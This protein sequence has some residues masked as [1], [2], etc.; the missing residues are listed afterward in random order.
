MKYLMM[1]LVVTLLVFTAGESLLYAGTTGKVVGKITD[2]AT[3]EPLISANVVIKGTSLGAVSDLDG[4][5]II[6]NIPPGVYSVGVSIIGYQRVQF[7]GVQ[8]NIDLTTTIDAALKAEAV[9]LETVVITAERKLVIKDMTSSLSTTTAD[10]IQ[11]LPVTNVQQVLRLN[12][13]ITESD[14]RLYI[15]GGRAAEVGY[16]VDGISATDLYNGKLG[17]TVENSAIQELQV[18]SGTFNAEYGQAMSG[19]VN[20]VTKEG[21]KKYTGQI[22]V[23]A[24]DYLSSAD[25]FSLYKSIATAKDTNRL[26]GGADY[27]TRIVSGERDYPLKKFNPVYNGEFS[28]SGPV[29]LTNDALTFFANGRYYYDEGYYYGREWFKPN[30]NLG[31]NVTDSVENPNTLN[32]VHVISGDNSNLVP[33]NPS[34]TM[35]LLGKLNYQLSGNIKLSYSIFWNSLERRRNYFRENSADYQFNVSGTA[36]FNPFNT[37]DF[38]YVPNALPQLFGEGLTNTFTINHILS[39]STFYELRASRYYSES[40]QYVYKNPLRVATYIDTSTTNTTKYTVAPNS[41]NGYIDPKEI[42]MGVAYTYFNKG[43]DMTHTERSSEYWVG[44]LDVTSQLNKAHQLKVGSE[45]RLHDLILHSYQIIAKTDS[46]GQDIKPFQPAI[47]EV[48]SPYRSDY[49]RQPKEISAYVQDKIEFNDI[50][51]NVG[52]R[53]D[54]FDANA[55]MPTDPTDPNIYGL[56][57]EAGPFKDEHKYRDTNGNGVID[58]SEKTKSNEYTPDERRAFMQEKVKAKMAISPRLGISFPITERGVIHFS[59]GHFLQIPEFQYLYTN[60]DF[61]ITSSTGKATLGN[62]DLRPQKTVQYEIGLQQQFTDVIGIDVTLFYRDV[63][64]WVGT[65]RLIETA[66]PSVSYSK[67]ENKDYENVKG[68]TFKIEKRFAEN[69]SFRVDYTLQMAEG[70]YTNPIDEL[71]AILGKQQP[72]LALIPMGFDRRH[73]LNAQFMY[74]IS[75]WTFSLIGRYFTGVPYTPSFTYSETVG[76]SGVSGLVNNSARRPD[77]KTVDLTINKLFSLNKNLSLEIFMNVYNLLDQRDQTNVYTDTESADYTTNT[78]PSRIPYNTSRIS[79]I[80][81]Y[82]NQPAWYTA[83]RQVQIGVTLGF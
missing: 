73:T 15:R 65:S 19:I 7:D 23:Y 5:Y 71:N 18:I 52:L 59:Y 3:G 79:T 16:W 25:E 36:N 69:Y 2:I 55:S 21:G 10:Q 40:K 62:P 26:A 72:A 61:K 43:M 17:I 20:V 42:S 58:N 9:E 45:V 46:S 33:L 4:N 57:S 31:K 11:N 60:P 13:G 49:D 38:K 22:K 28:L 53:Y 75:G 34:E 82:V 66:K 78:D 76:S 70:T 54:Y 41:P 8:V 35:S 56:G 29:P 37:H 6:L 24:G 39:P 64:D 80:E 51:L 77:Q 68:V 83:P 27:R 67:Y 74:D 30:G 48:G 81:D 47:P 50:I 1:I 32:E 14:G 12:A 63:R 44:K